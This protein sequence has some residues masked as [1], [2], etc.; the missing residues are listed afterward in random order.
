MLWLGCGGGDPAASDGSGSGGGDG[1]NDRDG[2]VSIDATPAVCGDGVRAR[3]EE[4]DDHNQTP[5][6]GCDENC[7]VEPFAG[8]PQAAIDAMHAINAARAQADDP[9]AKL[10]THVVTSSQNH[11]TYYATNAAAYANGL[12]PHDE[13]AS[14]P[15]GFTGVQFFTRM[16]AAGFGGTPMF[17]TMAFV[18]DAN[19]SVGE[20]LDTVFHR[21]PILHPN[22]AQFGYALST[23]GGRNND[24]ADFGSGTAEKPDAVITWPPPG[25]TNIPGAFDIA[26]EGP[27]PPAP[28]GGGGT[29]GP[30]VSVFFANNGGTIT[31][32]SIK[33]SAGHTLPDTLIAPNDPTFGPFMLGS[34]CFYADGPAPAHA[35]FTV[36]IAGTVGGQPFS[37]SW[38]FTTQ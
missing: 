17:E 26:Q 28:P 12:S 5:G 7:R 11:A 16:S 23:A 8:A 2:S 22:M 14:F 6:D 24:V 25:A 3:G 15:N 30:L 4:C 31:S 18:G 19:A 21:I 37:T 10:E 34:Y 1:G 9:G 33:D 29:T 13:D 27:T 36:D 38:S 35:T 32:H 20:W